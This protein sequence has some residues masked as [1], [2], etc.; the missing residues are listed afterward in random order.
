MSAFLDPTRSMAPLGHKVPSRTISAPH[1]SI[2]VPTPPC[3]NI[4][5]KRFSSQYLEGKRPEQ[6]PFS[7]NNLV[8][9]KVSSAF[10]LLTIPPSPL[11]PHERYPSLLTCTYLFFYDSKR[12]QTVLICS[13]VVPTWLAPGAYSTLRVTKIPFA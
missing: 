5:S 6:H 1:A 9:Q 3:L 7:R 10:G 8:L 13:L 2:P 12:F 4:Y 11:L